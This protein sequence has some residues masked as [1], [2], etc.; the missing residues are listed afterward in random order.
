MGS[1]HRGYFAPSTTVSH[2]DSANSAGIQVADIVAG[3]VF[4]GLE[5]SDATYIS[6][7]AGNV[8]HGELY[9]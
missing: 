2:L 4:R 5:R 1:H 8:V 7:T 6:L 3:A 9:W